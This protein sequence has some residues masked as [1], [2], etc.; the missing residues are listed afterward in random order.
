MKPL[1]FNLLRMITL[2]TQNYSFCESFEKEGFSADVSELQMAYDAGGGKI[3]HK[4]LLALKRIYKEHIVEGFDEDIKEYNEVVLPIEIKFDDEL[5]VMQLME[6]KIP[7]DVQKILEE[8]ASFVDT[9]KTL[10]ESFISVG[11]IEDLKEHHSEEVNNYLNK[12]FL[13]LNGADA[14]YLKI[15]KG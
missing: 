4:A 12:L 2:M 6:E 9:V 1:E 10:D 5:K 8:N 7:N 3:N 15:M 13:A 11:T 14:G